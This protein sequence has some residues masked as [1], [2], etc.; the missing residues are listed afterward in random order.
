M[1]RT[2]QAET[3][4]HT[5]YLQIRQALLR[6]EYASGHRFKLNELCADYAV[7]VSVVREVLT[8]LAEQGLAS[9]EPNK[10][11]SVPR[12]MIEEIDDLAFV[13]SELETIAIRRSI[14]R[15]DVQW[16]SG[17]LAAHYR[18]A[19][20][21][22]PSPQESLEAYEQWAL[23]HRS[24]HD[25]CAAACGSPQL[26]NMRSTLFHQFEIMRQLSNLGSG[27]NRDVA[28]EHADIFN[29]VMSRDV[30]Q[31]EEAVRRHIERT[32]STSTPPATKGRRRNPEKPRKAEGSI[33]ANLN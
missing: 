27:Q 24:F 5:L 28:Q 15:G 19:H 32:R 6:G 16:E 9:F 13:R 2:D 25:A 18:L 22:L 26:Q 29:A 1:A 14:E 7:S 4:N 33:A 23:V 17:V 30:D 20:T 8:R 11:F 21:P 12:P 3:R 10:G 31:A